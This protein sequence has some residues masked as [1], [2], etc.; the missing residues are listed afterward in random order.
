MGPR[1]YRIY[2]SESHSGEY[3]TICF[4]KPSKRTKKQQGRACFYATTRWL[5]LSQYRFI[6]SGLSRQLAS[7]NDASGLA[8]PPRLHTHIL[9][10]VG[11]VMKALSSSVCCRFSEPDFRE[12]WARRFRNLLFRDA[13]SDR[14]HAGT[15]FHGG[16]RAFLFR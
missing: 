3:K 7:D 6:D 11:P 5:I 14:F 2:S 16:G 9:E 1:E 12:A 4:H 10:L 8:H 15:L 13:L